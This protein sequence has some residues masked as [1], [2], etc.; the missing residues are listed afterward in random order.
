MSAKRNRITQRKVDQGMTTTY[1]IK[2]DRGHHGIFFWIIVLSIWFG[3]VLPLKL[4]AA[5]F[6][7]LFWTLPRYAFHLAQAH[8]ARTA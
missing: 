3:F 6:R 8:A 5:G 7:W 4:I 2:I 1:R